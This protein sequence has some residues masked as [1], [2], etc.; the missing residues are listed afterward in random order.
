[1]AVCFV[2]GSHA[3]MIP[4][5]PTPM[6]EKQFE[7]ITNMVAANFVVMSGWDWKSFSM[8]SEQRKQLNTQLGEMAKVLSQPATTNSQARC[9]TA[10]NLH[11]LAHAGLMTERSV[12]PHLIAGLKTE[13]GNLAD[14]THAD[15]LCALSLMTRRMLG[16]VCFGGPYLSS[17][18]SSNGAAITAW[19]EEW[20]KNNQNRSPVYDEK[21]DQKVRMEY[22]RTVKAIEDNVKSKYP[23]LAYF[24]ARI[25]LL[26]CIHQLYEDEYA[27]FLF[28]FP[29]WPGTNMTR[30]LPHDQQPWL[31]IAC[32]FKNPEMPTEWEEWR[33]RRPPKNLENFM[34]CVYSNSIEGTSIFVEVNIASPNRG[35]VDSL[36]KA[37]A[38]ARDKPPPS[39]DEMPSPTVY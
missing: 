35:L 20:W 10:A 24:K 25:P 18:T 14:S 8:S 3:G 26:N 22:Y 37:L 4:E 39:S 6:P 34:T 29:N 28:S 7:T 23:E 21:I 33:T 5:G 16:T 17:N 19:W 1:M 38:D 27:P 36:R 9:R 12:I 15:S 31:M 13:P 11:Y 30:F 32:R 2:S